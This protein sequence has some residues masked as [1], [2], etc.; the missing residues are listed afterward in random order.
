MRK[1]EK[2]RQTFAVVLSVW[3]LSLN[4]PPGAVRSAPGDGIFW[5]V[6]HRGESSTQTDVRYYLISDI[7]S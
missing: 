5:S 3:E 7:A 2:K 6:C 4:L 1:L